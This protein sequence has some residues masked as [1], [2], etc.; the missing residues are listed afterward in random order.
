VIAM[1]A[2]L[3]C[4]SHAAA[5]ERIFVNGFD[6]CCRIGGMVSGLSENGLVLHLASSGIAEDRPIASYGVYDFTKSV[7]PGKAYTLSVKTQPTGQTCA[8]AK[9]TGTMGNSD[10]VDAN[11][12]CTGGNKLL[13]DIGTWGQDWK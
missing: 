9:T 3:P 8:L 13:W 12:T 1:T 6:P 5:S 11:V 2:L 7:A 4:L 10:V